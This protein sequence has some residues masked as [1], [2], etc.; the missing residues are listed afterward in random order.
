MIG[1]HFRPGGASAFFGFPLDELRNRVVDLDAIWNT[2]AQ[3]LRDQ[4]LEAP[5]PA[6]KFRV[7]E[8]ALLARWRAATSHHRAVVHALGCFTREPESMTIGK[9]MGEI[10]LSPRRFIEVFTRQ[11]GITPKL[12]CR[13]RRFQRALGEIHRSRD[14]IWTD[15]ATGCGYYDQAHFINEFREFCGITPG[16]Y[17]KERPESRTLSRFRLG[18]I[19]PIRARRAPLCSGRMNPNQINWLAVL[20][21]AVSAFVVGGLWYSPILF[22]KAWL[23]ANGF[24][25]AQAQSFSRARAFGGAFVLALIMSA[26]LAMFLADATTTVLWGDDGR[27]RLPVSAG[28][29]QVLPLSRCSRIVSWTY[30]LVNGGYLAVSFVLM[31]AILGAWR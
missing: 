17:L 27:L 22:G 5:N 21:A 23:K 14:V 1:A 30:I 13:V 15:I 19:L 6:A 28:L 3:S 25:E 29:Q 11:V 7:L 16:D 2:S 26:N 12:F 20:A 24:T 8:E 18:K 9:I 10:G 4:L 31:G